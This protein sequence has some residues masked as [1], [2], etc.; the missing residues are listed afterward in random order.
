MKNV[1][2]LLGTIG[3]P[4]LVERYLDGREI[5]IGIIGNNE[6]IRTLP[7]LEIVY[8]EGDKFLTFNKKEMDNDDFICPANITEAELI[9]LQNIS[10]NAFRALGLRDYAR[11]DT[12]LTPQGFMFLESNSF[13][14][15]MCTPK[16]KPN[17][18]IGFMARAEGNSG[19]ELIQEIIEAAL[20]RINK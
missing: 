7:P 20:E 3:Q 17:S 15:L 8:K 12:K 13:A 2:N 4:V 18:C 10:I 5:T 9:D 19:K 14:G 11:I 6:H 16:E 1:K